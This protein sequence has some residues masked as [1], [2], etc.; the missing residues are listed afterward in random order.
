MSNETNAPG[1][2]P[3]ELSPMQEALREEVKKLAAARG[4]LIQHQT[5]GRR[6]RKLPRS[7]STRCTALAY[8]GT[9]VTM[10]GEVTSISGPW[11]WFVANYPG[12]G[13]WVAVVHV[14]ACEYL[15]R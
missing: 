9:V 11:R 12:W 14:N 5:T 13:E 3:S 10:V 2:K 8:D 7:I 4:K 15:D 6:S 1:V